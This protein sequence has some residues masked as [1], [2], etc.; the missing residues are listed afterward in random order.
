MRTFLRTGLFSTSWDRA[1]GP[2]WKPGIPPRGIMW[3]Q[4]PGPQPG[5][6][7]GG[8][9]PCRSIRCERRYRQNC[10]FW[11]ICRSY[12]SRRCCM[13]RRHTRQA[14]DIE[15]K[16]TPAAPGPPDGAGRLLRCAG[17][18]YGVCGSGLSQGMP[19]AAPGILG[20]GVRRFPSFWAAPAAPFS[21]SRPWA[22][23]MDVRPHC[24]GGFETGRM[25]GRPA[26]LAVFVGLCY[27]DFVYRLTSESGGNVYAGNRNR[28][29]AAEP[30][31]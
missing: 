17:P 11:N 29:L 10:M 19:E 9:I 8:A 12:N 21:F 22:S 15:W 7:Q 31:W 27:N 6:P 18:L 16:S 26:T 4:R 2:P 30:V 14:A 24:G 25:G 20:R 28:A 3:D 13:D 5:M 1:P 23:G